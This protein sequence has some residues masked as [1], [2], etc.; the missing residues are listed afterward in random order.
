MPH[1][2]KLDNIKITYL[3]GIQIIDYQQL[4]KLKLWP[5]QQS[6]VLLTAMNTEMVIK[7]KCFH[8]ITNKIK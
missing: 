5:R 4:Q 7:K 1:G 8:T 2:F 3:P 6:N